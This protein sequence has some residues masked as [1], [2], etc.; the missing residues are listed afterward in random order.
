V[1][2]TMGFE[3]IS[4]PFGF[5]FGERLLLGLKGGMQK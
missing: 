4:M 5:I 1:A 2:G 3:L